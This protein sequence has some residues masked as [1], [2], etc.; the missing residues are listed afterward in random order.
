MAAGHKG[1]GLFG[2]RA[3]SEIPECHGIHGVHES[4]SPRFFEEGFP[5]AKRL[6]K[7]Q[8][9]VEGG[10]VR[11]YRPLLE[12]SKA[13][14]IATCLE[15][16]M[17]WFE[18]P[19]NSDPTLT[20]RNAIR[21]LYSHHQVPAALSKDRLLSLSQTIS[22]I[23]ENK[24]RLINR[25]LDKC[26]INL[27][28]TMHGVLEIRFV[29]LSQYVTDHIGHF[30]GLEKEK[31]ESESVE[32]NPLVQSDLL[33]GSAIEVVDDPKEHLP[34][35]TPN[36]NFEPMA[37]ELLRRVIM[38]VS[39]KEKVATSTLHDTVNRIFPE[40]LPTAQRLNTSNPEAFT[41]AGV[42]FQPLQTPDQESSASDKTPKCRYRISRQPL[43]HVEVKEL[44]TLV[45]SAPFTTKWGPWHLY[46]NRFWIRFQLLDS[47][48]TTK[49][50]IYLTPFRPEYRPNFI[51]NPPYPNR[52]QRRKMR[53]DGI[54]R[55]QSYERFLK[56]LGPGRVRF[57]LPAIVMDLNETTKNPADNKL[58]GLPSMKRGFEGVDR[59]IRWECRYKK[60]YLDG[61]RFNLRGRSSAESSHRGRGGAGQSK[62]NWWGVE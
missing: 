16:K 6:R 17:P 5:N 12:F 61:F 27:F 24:Q 25:W 44:T 33:S 4:G 39:P 37:A 47:E 2:I 22:K 57:T 30:S 51:P 41:V 21:H 42:F 53:F 10:G 26:D 52:V 23:Y 62:G 43:K 55:K 28:S 58:L 60:L 40:L 50:K 49:H 19:T 7:Y 34:Q 36:H 46:D 15:S 48:T 59:L 35:S 13:R 29:D 9:P 38:L 20:T 54:V 32:S 3:Q 8:L 1:R 14:L 45:S 18:D 11:V 31:Q 56:L